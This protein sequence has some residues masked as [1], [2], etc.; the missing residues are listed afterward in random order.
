MLVLSEIGKLTHWED[1]SGGVGQVGLSQEESDD[2]DAVGVGVLE[3]QLNH[4]PTPNGERVRADHGGPVELEH[5][6]HA[7]GGDLVPGGVGD[8]VQVAEV[9]EPAWLLHEED[10]EDRSKYL[11]AETEQRPGGADP[12]GQDS[13]LGS[14]GDLSVDGGDLGLAGVLV[15]GGFDLQGIVIN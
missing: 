8:V 15:P 10:G 11:G 6:V 7:E 1:I 9:G 13:P 3:E 14:G 2:V 5:L 12:Q 4:P